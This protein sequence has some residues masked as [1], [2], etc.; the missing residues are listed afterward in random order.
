MDTTSDEVTCYSIQ[1]PKQ[2]KTSKF[3]EEFF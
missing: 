1:K 3:D 2:K